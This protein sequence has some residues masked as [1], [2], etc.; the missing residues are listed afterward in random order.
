MKDDKND[1]GQMGRILSRREVVALF[2]AAAGAGLLVEAGDAQC[3]VRPQQ[4]EGPK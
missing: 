1:D 2:G 3:I 4:T